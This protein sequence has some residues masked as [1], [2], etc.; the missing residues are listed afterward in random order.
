MCDFCK[1]I[2]KE[3]NACVVHETEK[4]IAFLDY[5]PINEGH[6]LICPKVHEDSITKIPD[7]TLKD[8]LGITRKLVVAFEKKYGAKGYT[9]MQNGGENCDYGHFHVHVFPRY[10]GDGFGW[11]DSGKEH[12]YS[13]EVA[14]GL[15]E[16]L[17]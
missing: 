3:I 14:D 11:V 16:F 10:E 13:Q 7:D 1:I 12:P 15:K 4:N 5:G 2:N 17:I 8:L 6:V 9:I